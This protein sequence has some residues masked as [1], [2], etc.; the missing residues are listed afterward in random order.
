MPPRSLVAV[1]PRHILT[2]RFH[3]VPISIC[4]VSLK[5]ILW[6]LFSRSVFSLSLSLPVLSLVHSLAIIS[7]YSSYCACGHS[8][9]VFALPGLIILLPVITFL[10]AATHVSRLPC[11]SVTLLCSRLA[12]LANPKHLLTMSHP[13]FPLALFSICS[14]LFIFLLSPAYTQI[15]PLTLS[16]AP[17]DQG[18]AA[19]HWCGPHYV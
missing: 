18:G 19:A 4:F 9:W 11:C 5:Y 7:P 12:P 8:P 14:P 13:R 6:E 2:P 15:Y 17:L 3:V 16:S 10:S 1:H